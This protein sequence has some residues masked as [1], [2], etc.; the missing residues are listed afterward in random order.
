M[1]LIMDQ[2]AP[3]YARVAQRVADDIQSGRYPR[4][5]MLPPELDLCERFGVSRT[6]MRAAIRELQVR[7]MVSRRAG[8]GTRVEAS[9]PQ[10]QFVHESTTFEGVIQFTGAMTFRM[11]EVGEEIADEARAT[12]L[13]CAPGERLTVLR[14]MRVVPPGK[15]LCISNHFISGLDRG[16]AARFDGLTGPLATALEMQV[17]RRI[18]MIRQR[19][20]A[21]NLGAAE[22][23]LLDTIRGAAALETWR[24]YFADGD[25][26]L[27]A[28]NSIFPGDRYASTQALRRQPRAH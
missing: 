11:I 17:G 16:A 20:G 22:A 21:I 27:M 18:D 10:D 4:G 5:A 3:L 7:G 9:A 2:S 25:R 19:I 6:T 15:P 1:A 23:K 28:S 12:W 26:L 8:V 24:W 14:G 13:C